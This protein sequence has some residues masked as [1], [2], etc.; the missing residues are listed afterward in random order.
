[1]DKCAACGQFCLGHETD[2]TNQ[3]ILIAHASEDHSS[4]HPDGCSSVGRSFHA[5]L[6]TN[7]GGDSPCVGTRTANVCDTFDGFCKT[8]FV[9]LS[10]AEYLVKS[11]EIDATALNEH[12]RMRNTAEPPVT[13]SE[14][15][16]A[17]TGGSTLKRVRKNFGPHRPTE[18]AQEPFKRGILRK[19]PNGEPDELSVRMQEWADKKLEEYQGKHEGE[20]SALLKTLKWFEL[21]GSTENTTELPAWL[22]EARSRIEDDFEIEKKSSI[23]LTA[24]D[25]IEFPSG[26]LLHSDGLEES[27][28][29]HPAG[30]GSNE[31]YDWEANRQ[32]RSP[33]QETKT[34]RERVDK[35]LDFL[36]LD[37]P[38]KPYDRKTD[39]IGEL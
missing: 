39:S 13:E 35:A 18:S 5:H 36:G 7:C 25:V 4:C 26:K 38:T 2:S 37:D 31:V 19:G 10:R 17:E 33:R 22:I 16:A 8:C 23:E 14:V 1:M 15:K 28:Q 12:R 32:F 27:M 21:M 30:K 24:G 29:R 9:E 3:I 11:A 6:C 20:P 34:L